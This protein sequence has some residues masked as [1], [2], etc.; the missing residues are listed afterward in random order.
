M[1]VYGVITAAIVRKIKALIAEYRKLVVEATVVEKSIVGAAETEAVKIIS[2]ALAAAKTIIG[3]AKFE[4]EVIKNNVEGETSK[5]K[6][7]LIDKIA[8]L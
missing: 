7:E 1:T 3:R 4:V 8:K 5:L 2:E 6:N